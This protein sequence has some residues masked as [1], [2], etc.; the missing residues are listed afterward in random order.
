MPD[1]IPLP[2]VSP[3]LTAA[4]EQARLRRE[5][6][7]LVA[8]NTGLRREIAAVREQLANALHPNTEEN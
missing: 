4:D 8:E 6:R 3:D 2:R 5:N 1:L 7:L